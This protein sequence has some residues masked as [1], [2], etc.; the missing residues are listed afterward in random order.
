[1]IRSIGTL[2]LIR[3]IEVLSFMVGVIMNSSFRLFAALLIQLALFAPFSFADTLSA[4]GVAGDIDSK[5]RNPHVTV[6]ATVGSNQVT[7][8]ADAFHPSDEFKK[9]PIQ[10]DFFVNRTLFAS[11]YRSPTLEGPV[12]V[13]VPSSVATPPFNYVVVAKVLHPNSVYTTV[14][15]GAV[16]ST[17][18]SATV[19]CTLTLPAATE[20][21]EDTIFTASG[22]ALGQSSNSNV[23]ASFSAVSQDGKRTVQVNTQA[24]VVT[25]SSG[26]VTVTEDGNE[27][28]FSGEATVEKDDTGVS[29]LTIT[30]DDG[31]STLSCAR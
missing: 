15:E 30:S 25:P 5:N 14:I 19:D 2:Y 16:F 7:I 28:S 24:T 10:F 9:Y 22:V 12:G 26:T 8:L 29:S 4:E 21:A 31:N 27:S 3:D 13:T 18:L 11:Q 6:G 1:M 23:D 17:S 20:G